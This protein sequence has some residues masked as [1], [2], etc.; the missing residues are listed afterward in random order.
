MLDSPQAA[1]DARETSYKAISLAA[2]VKSTPAS[3]H[4]LRLNEIPNLAPDS[5][6]RLSFY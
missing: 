4:F 1:L 3:D 5:E 6:I 2:F